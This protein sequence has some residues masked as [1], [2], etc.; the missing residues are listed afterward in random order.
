MQKL[1]NK[2]QE[3][4]GKALLGCESA[5]AESYI[6]Y[7]LFS[8]NRFNINYRVGRPVPVYAYVFHEYVNNFMG[9]QVCLHY[10]VDY[11]KTPFSLLE[12]IAYSFMAGDMLTVVLNQNGD[13]VWNW[14]QPVD[15]PLPEQESVKLLIKRTNS[16]RQGWAKKYLHSGKMIKHCDVTCDSNELIYNIGGL[17]VPKIYTSAWR[18]EDGSTAQFLINYNTEDTSC[19]VHL[20]EGEYSLFENDKQYTMI[21]GGKQQVIVK[22]LSV[23]MIK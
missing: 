23:Y 4:A 20:P 6:P 19:V 7:L 12:R 5:A 22:A 18:A 17:T 15:M 21:S 8:D 1:L 16:W 2:A 10:R 11:E 14:G 13:I 3:T 9:N